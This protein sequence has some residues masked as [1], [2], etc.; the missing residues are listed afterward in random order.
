M[1]TKN[2]DLEK[3][4]VIPALVRKFVDDENVV[5][6]GSGKPTRDFV[7]AGDVAVGLQAGETYEPGTP[8]STGIRYLEGP[9]RFGLPV[10]HQFTGRSCE[11]C[12]MVSYKS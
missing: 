1:F 7:Y 12:G 2:F 5:V 4:H 3:A 11:N 9:R 6:W 8:D 10:P